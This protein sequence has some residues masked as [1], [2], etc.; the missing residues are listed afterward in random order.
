[1]E[2]FDKIGGCFGKRRECGFWIRGVGVWVGEVGRGSMALIASSLSSRGFRGRGALIDW[3]TIEGGLS[4][5]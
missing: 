2:G 1:M 5:C 4:I 3:E